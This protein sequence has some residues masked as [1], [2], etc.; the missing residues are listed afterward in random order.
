MLHP[1][2]YMLPYV[3]THIYYIYAYMLDMCVDVYSP[4]IC[5]VHQLRTAQ[6]RVYNIV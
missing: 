4:Y 1:T 6:V 2:P 3:R 5:P